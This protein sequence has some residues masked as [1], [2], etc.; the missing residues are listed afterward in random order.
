MAKKQTRKS[1][2]VRGATYD[3]LR[4]YCEQQERSMSDVVEELLAGLFDSA[5]PV[6]RSVSRP[7]PVAAAKVARVPSGSVGRPAPTPARKVIPSRTRAPKN[8]YR[9]INF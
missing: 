2:S 1:I 7:R 8:D 3:T 5:V 9:N 4:G 6:S